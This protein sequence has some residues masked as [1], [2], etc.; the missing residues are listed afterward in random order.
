MLNETAKHE[1]RDLDVPLILFDLQNLPSIFFYDGEVPRLLKRKHTELLGVETLDGA[2][3]DISVTVTA[4]PGYGFELWFCIKTAIGTENMKVDIDK[5]VLTSLDLKIY[6]H[7]CLCD[8]AR[9]DQLI[10]AYPENYSQ[11]FY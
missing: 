11:D 6:M 4:K 3:A 7:I 10:N 8:R 5:P 1:H 2:Q 9:K